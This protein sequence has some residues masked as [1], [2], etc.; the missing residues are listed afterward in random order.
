MIWIRFEQMVTIWN[1]RDVPYFCTMTVVNINL[2]VG[3]VHYS[4]IAAQRRWILNCSTNRVSY[5]KINKFS[6]MF[7]SP[8]WVLID[9]L[10]RKPSKTVPV[11]LLEMEFKASLVLESNWYDGSLIHKTLMKHL[12]ECF[13]SYAT[14][15]THDK[16]LEM[17]VVCTEFVQLFNYHA[18]LRKEESK[19]IVSSKFYSFLLILKNYQ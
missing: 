19:T 18:R 6:S 12:L 1:W 10:C 8:T 14:T 9:S 11:Y 3:T 5:I 17:G 16:V 15:W 13:F 2:L 7:T 4:Y